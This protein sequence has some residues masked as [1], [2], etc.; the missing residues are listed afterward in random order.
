VLQPKFAA[1]ARSREFILLALPLPLWL[2]Y[3]AVV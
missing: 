1:F 3:N 2:A